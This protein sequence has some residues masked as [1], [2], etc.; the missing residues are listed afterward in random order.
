MKKNQDR[1]SVNYNE[2]ENI[3]TWTLGENTTS[4]QVDDLTQDI[5]HQSKIHG[6]R[7]KVGDAMA[8]PRNELTGH[9]ATISEK[10]A[11]LVAMVERLKAGEW[12][13]GRE[14]GSNISILLIKALYEFYKGEKSMDYIRKNL[15]EKTPQE[16]K[17]LSLNPKIAKIIQKLEAEQVKNLSIDS[18]DLLDNF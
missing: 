14:G 12:N 6:I 5:Q 8:I 7:Q 9:S 17:A 1:V 16:R 15:S 13:V 4:L 3:L 10:W 11:A 2:A 18:D